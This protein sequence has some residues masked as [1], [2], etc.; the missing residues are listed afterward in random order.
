M[1]K[2]SDEKKA[3][4]IREMNQKEN[5]DIFVVQIDD[6]IDI[7]RKIRHKMK[8]FDLQNENAQ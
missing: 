4:G 2:G 8:K 5:N 7:Q 3:A 6:A 1:I